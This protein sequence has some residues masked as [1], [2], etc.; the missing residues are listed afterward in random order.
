MLIHGLVVASWRRS[1]ATQAPERWSSGAA[2]ASG[3]FQND[4]GGERAGRAGGGG[5]GRGI[6]PG[7]GL[8]RRGG[9][10]RR[11]DSGP[12]A[13][14]GLR[15]D[16]RGRGDLRGR[17]CGADAGDGGGGARGRSGAAVRHEGDLRGRDAAA[18]PAEADGALGRHAGAGRGPAAAVDAQA[19]AVRGGVERH[20]DR[21]PAAARRRAPPRASGRTRSAVRR[22][23]HRG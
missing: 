9:D 4:G 20:L 5:V 8:R 2:A 18:R 1:S 19:D 13:G 16:G 14:R 6:G 21:A 11:R 17:G 10:D 3:A 7:D 12:D 22:G 15:G 23:G